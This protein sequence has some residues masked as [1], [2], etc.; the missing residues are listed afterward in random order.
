[1]TFKERVKRRTHIESRYDSI[2][3]FGEKAEHPP[4]KSKGVRGMYKQIKGRNPVERLIREKDA[5]LAF[6]FNSNCFLTLKGAEIYAR[7][8]GFISTARKNNRCVFTILFTTFEGR[9]FI[10]E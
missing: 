9:N 1:M 10:T 5:V 3:G 4:F 2:C 6:A 7:I 8:E